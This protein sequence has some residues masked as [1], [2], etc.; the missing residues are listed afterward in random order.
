MKA[1]AVIQ[2]ARESSEELKQLHETWI[3]SNGAE[4]LMCLNYDVF[5]KRYNRT[6]EQI[7]N[8]FEKETGMI[9]IDKKEYLANKKESN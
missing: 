3:A 8:D 9:V 7:L 1:E 2:M 4:G 5:L 6:D